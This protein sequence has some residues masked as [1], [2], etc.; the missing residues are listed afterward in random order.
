MAFITPSHAPVAKPFFS[1]FTSTCRGIGGQKWFTHS[2]TRV[3]RMSSSPTVTNR[4]SL[5]GKTVV[6]TGGHRGIGRDISIAAAQA[7]ADIVVIDRHGP[8]ASDVPSTLETLGR[9]YY[10]FQANLLNAS[11]IS[12]A[13]EQALKTVGPVDAL[14][15][16]AGITRLAPFEELSIE[17][18]DETI[19]VN[20][21]APFLMTQAF[22]K[23]PSGML[24]RGRGAIV[25]VTSV[26]GS[27][28]FDHHA[29]YCA[30]KAGLDML[31]KVITCEWGKKGIRANAVAPTV[32]MTAMGKEVWGKPEAGD[33]M[34]AKIPQGRFAEPSEVADAVV[35]LC[36][37][38][39]SMINGAV[40]PVDG[41]F[42]CV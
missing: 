31:T 13:V 12:Q 5:A 22:A 34:L 37:D 6:V 1:S 21:R 25:N 30:S 23:G 38:A 19:A 9:R 14:V 42:G 33:P 24:A 17:Q 3:M 39:S 4:F 20:L 16:N 2:F 28:A 15:N 29:A 8:D 18:W 41:G 10:S 11:D 35:Y 27:F 36:S 26:A 40:L 32:V 7:G